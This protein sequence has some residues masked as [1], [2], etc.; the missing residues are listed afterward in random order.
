MKIFI[1]IAI[2]LTG[3]TQISQHW[4]LTADEIQLGKELAEQ[5]GYE[6][7]YNFTFEGN[8]FIGARI[9]HEAVPFADQARSTL[10]YNYN[11]WTYDK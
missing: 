6:L 5:A 8:Y 4:Y 7:R 10:I 3:C 1:I 11:W 9:T 2:L